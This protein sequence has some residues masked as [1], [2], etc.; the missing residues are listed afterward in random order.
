MMR[1]S[2]VIPMSIGVAI[3]NLNV[4]IGLFFTL[5]NVFVKMFLG[6]LAE[7][8]NIITSRYRPEASL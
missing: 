7:K 8:S 1:N 4:N 6:V 2:N 5:S 3:G